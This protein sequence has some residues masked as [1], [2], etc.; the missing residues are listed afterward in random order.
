MDCVLRS[1]AY[2]INVHPNY[3]IEL[4]G[5]DGTECI[6]RELESPF[7]YRGFNIFEMSRVL[8][9]LGYTTTIINKHD[10]VL[11]SMMKEPKIINADVDH[12]SPLLTSTKV[13]CLSNNNHM[14]GVKHNIVLDVNNKIFNVNRFDY[15]MMYI[16]SQM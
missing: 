9:G 14:I 7:C 16:I 4:L 15:N 13:Y 5:H 3:L 6:N 2:C 10:M 11:N 1:F 8:Y 12:I